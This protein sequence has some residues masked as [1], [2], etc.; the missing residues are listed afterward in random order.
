MSHLA[1][2]FLRLLLASTLF[3]YAYGCCHCFASARDMYH[4]CYPFSDKGYAN[5]SEDMRCRNHM[6][7]GYLQLQHIQIAVES[8][9]V[10]EVQYLC[11]KMI[12]ELQRAA[13]KFKKQDPE[14]GPLEN[15][16]NI[17]RN[18]AIEYTNKLD[19]L[20]KPQPCI[21]SCGYQK[22]A[23]HFNCYTCEIRECSKNLNCGKKEVAVEESKSVTMECTVPFELP[24]DSVITWKFAKRENTTDLSVFKK[25]FSGRDKF[26]TI[27]NAEAAHEGTYMCQ[28]ED[29]KFVFARLFFHVKLKERDR[30]QEI[31]LQKIFDRVIASNEIYEPYKELTKS[32]VKGLMEHLTEDKSAVGLLVLGVALAVMIVLLMAGVLYWWSS[33]TTD[34]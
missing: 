12:Q 6:R 5:F 22:F 30:R 14:A 10:R 20:K 16:T 32:E 23:D 29:K 2:L 21:G 8:D 34:D 26:C 11:N 31:E 15:F 7:D 27:R 28:L 17:Q 3:G 19:G 33:R 18:I 9:G 25:I 4:F 24:V 1:L 13:S